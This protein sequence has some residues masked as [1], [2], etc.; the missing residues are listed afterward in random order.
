MTTPT[1]ASS[2]LLL[3]TVLVFD[4]VKALLQRETSLLDDFRGDGTVFLVTSVTLATEFVFRF[5]LSADFF[6]DW[7][8]LTELEA[9]PK[10]LL[11]ISFL[12]RSP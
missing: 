1:S 11:L 6:G 12:S 9:R 2:L 10:A 3:E 7:F 5:S 4:G 8:T